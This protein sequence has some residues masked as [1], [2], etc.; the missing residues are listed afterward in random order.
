MGQQQVQA[1]VEALLA[2][3]ASFSSGELTEATGLTRQALNRY[4]ADWVQRG[5]LV[6]EGRGRATRYGR[7]GAATFERTYP[8]AGLADDVPWHELSDWLSAGEHEGSDA[9]NL[10]LYHVVTELVNNAIDH[11]DSTHVRLRAAIS[12]GRIVVAIVDEGIGAF[13]RL[14]SGLGLEDHFHAAQEL[15]KGKVTTQPDR[16]SGEGLFFSSK[17]VAHFELI[18]N[19]VDWLVDNEIDDQALLEVALR[20]GTEVRVALLLASTRKPEDVFASYTHD[21]K[22]D[23][24]RCVVRLFEHG[25][26][27]VSRSQAKRLAAGLE[28]FSEV[29]LDFQGVEGVG[30]GFVDE[31]FRVWARAHPGTRLEPRNMNAAV[32]FMVRRGLPARE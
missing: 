27:F 10:V 29:V 1:A 23:T 3:R 24:T 25:V 31:I 30:Q 18:A 17:M 16:H 2:T 20:P 12:D 13:E 32:E 11:S 19:G 4:L 26:R 9:A 28:K 22:F 14:R 6:R 15:S 8:I 7:A 21:F 5:D